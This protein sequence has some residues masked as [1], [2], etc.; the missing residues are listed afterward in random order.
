MVPAPKFFLAPKLPRLPHKYHRVSATRPCLSRYN[1]DRHRRLKSQVSRSN[2]TEELHGYV[3]WKV[4]IVFFEVYERL[5]PP[6]FGDVMVAVV[7]V[8]LVGWIAF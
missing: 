1:L 3:S 5:M 4:S 7:L 8:S 2:N 6:H